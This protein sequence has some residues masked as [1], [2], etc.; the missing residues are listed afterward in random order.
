M[1]ALSAFAKYVR[2]EVA[3]CPEI[4]ILDAILRAGIQFCKESRAVKQPSSITTVAGTSE[5]AITLPTGLIPEEILSVKRG[6]FDDLEASSFH[7]FQNKNLHSISG[8]PG[9]FYMNESDKLVLGA[10]PN[11]AETLDVWL[12]VRPIEDATVLPDLLF[13]RYRYEIAHGAKS[14][15]M[16]MKDKPWTDIQQAGIY[17]TLFN[18]AIAESNVRDAKGASGKRLRTVAHHF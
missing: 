2:P 4:E 12:R 9:Y 1:A 8:A 17:Q 14:I 6:Q 11:S 5:Y 7:S 13:S 3:G 18:D 10:I 15:L 16:L